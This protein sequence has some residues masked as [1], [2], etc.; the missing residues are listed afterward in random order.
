V[1]QS[2]TSSDTSAS[3]RAILLTLLTVIGFAAMNGTNKYLT[4]DYP[5]AQV[6]WARFFFANLGIML[7]ALWRP[8][9]KALVRTRRPGLQALRSALMICST[10]L[11]VGSLSLLPLAE[12]EAIN[13]AGPFFVVALSA[14]MLKERVPAEIWIA[15]IVGFVGILV[16][17][18]PGAGV[19]SW[20]ALMPIAVAFLYALFQ[21]VTRRLG[22]ADGAITSLFYS[23]L[24]GL[25]ITSLAAPFV[26]RWP[27]L[28]GWLLM[29]QA[30][31][32][33]AGSHFLL[34][35]ALDLA[36]ASILQPFTYAQ[37]IAA[38]IIGYVVFD[39]VPDV[40][41]WLGSAIVVASGL[42]VLLRQR[43]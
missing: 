23:G 43:R 32:L 19:L 27:D 3:L 28:K 36:P 25:I 1:S 39:N 15:V 26:W 18:R 22:G 30:G 42:Y 14:P 7:V 40:W 6:V 37:L 10:L 29:A 9:L 8:G 12:V 34:I 4:I 21:I 41:T 31:L 20:A 24:L 35:K 11:F 17:I 5:V 13:F 33:G 16:I 2:P 38:V